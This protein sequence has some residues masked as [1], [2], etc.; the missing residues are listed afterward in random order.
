MGLTDDIITDEAVFFD[1]DDGAEFIAYT[2]NKG[3]PVDCLAVF[4]ETST[5]IMSTN[6]FSSTD[7]EGTI[8]IPKSVGFVP[9]NGDKL[10]RKKDK[11]LWRVNSIISQDF[12]CYT[13]SCSRKILQ[14]VLN[15]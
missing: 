11:L 12:I 5:G 6:D 10:I 9:E 13:L 4:N 7:S 8:C 2:P 14:K 1:E 15:K 3:Q